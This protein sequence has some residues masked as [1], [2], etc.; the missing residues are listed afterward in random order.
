MIAQVLPGGPVEANIGVGGL[1]LATLVLG[2]VIIAVVVVTIVFVI[3][4][5][6]P[7]AVAAD[8]RSQVAR[9]QEMQASIATL[10]A[11][12]RQLLEMWAEARSE[13]QRERQLRQAAEAKLAGVEERLRILRDQLEEEKLI[14]PQV[15]EEVS[16]LGIWPDTPGQPALDQSAEADALY[17]A[18]YS[19]TALRGPRANR[20]GVIL[21]VTRLRPTVVQVGS[22]GDKDGIMLSDGV[23]EPGWWGRVFAGKGV[24]LMVLLSCDSSQQDEINVSDALIAAGVKA[25]VSCDSAIGDKDAVRFAQLLYAML[26]QRMPLATAVQQ[27]K[28]SVSRKAGEMIRLREGA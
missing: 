26:S 2:G 15:T 8:L 16:V 12:Q 13:A 3:L 1:D 27:A 28:L 7:Q 23:A 22:H 18:G 25:V 19:Y 20:A 10:Q 21:E 24:N 9:S 17:N 14:K 5:F 4:R 6:W 11:Q